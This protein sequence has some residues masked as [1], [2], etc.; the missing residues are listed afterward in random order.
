MWQRIRAIARRVGRVPSPVFAGLY[1]L[2]IPAFALVYTR[3]SHGFY[4][5]TVR[6]ESALNAEADKILTGLREEIIVQFRE[7]HGAAR[8]DVADWAFNVE[9]IRLYALKPEDTRI[10]FTLR[11][12]LS[13]KGVMAG[14][15]QYAGT[16]VTIDARIRLAVGFPGAPDCRIFAETVV[17]SDSFPVP[18]E[19]L[20]PARIGSLAAATNKTS[21][22]ISER[23]HREIV[24]YLNAIKGFPQAASG[25]FARMF[26]FSAV[27]ITTLGYGDIVPITDSARIAVAVESILG[28]VLVGLFIN[29][30]FREQKP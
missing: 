23:L 25:S 5:S 9:D 18:P 20:F 22:A 11:T 21:L 8:I 1:L 6:Y 17:S 29:S 14:V 2:A 3:M 4:H 19:T 7:E 16:D 26:Y 10:T 28:I 12:E 13:G 15:R 30:V 27:T 24:G